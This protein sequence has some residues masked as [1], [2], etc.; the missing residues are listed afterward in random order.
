MKAEEYLRPFMSPERWR[1][2]EQ[3]KAKAPHYLSQARIARRESEA[4]HAKSVRRSEL[5]AERAAKAERDAPIL[6]RNADHRAR[7]AKAQ[8]RIAELDAKSKEPPPQPQYRQAVHYV[9][10]YRQSGIYSWV[11]T[12]PETIWILEEQQSE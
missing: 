11:E 10:R 6:A 2:V 8:A 9:Q 3:G 5:D 4:E 12:V 7:L 1:A